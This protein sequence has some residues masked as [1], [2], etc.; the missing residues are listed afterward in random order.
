[1]I[2]DH[3]EYW[4]PPAAGE[5]R[6][7]RIGMNKKRALRRALPQR[8]DRA[9][10]A[11]PTYS[12]LGHGRL[13]DRHVFFDLRR[14]NDPRTVQG[15][16]GLVPPARQQAQA[17]EPS[18][19]NLARA[20]EGRACSRTTG[21][22]SRVHRV[23]EGC[24]RRRRTR[25]G[26]SGRPLHVVCLKWIRRT[27]PTRP[28]AGRSSQQ[29]VPMKVRPTRVPPRF[30]DGHP[31]ATLRH[32]AVRLNGPGIATIWR[33]APPARAVPHKGMFAC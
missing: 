3:C 19:L 24:G 25:Q 17:A 10:S 1:M 27:E 11:R 30:F 6:A 32:C 21:C 16:A 31:T 12:A 18:P 15:S 9:T 13:D 23:R 33:I 7:A 22:A 2:D 20:E 8:P 4:D 28:I 26:V 29:V 14:R 5:G